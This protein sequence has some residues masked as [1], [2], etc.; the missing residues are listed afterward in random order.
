MTDITFSTEKMTYPS[1]YRK[2]VA[3]RQSQVGM[4]FL[5]FKD[6]FLPNDS[7]LHTVNHFLTPDYSAD[8]NPD[9]NLPMLKNETWKIYFKHQTTP[10]GPESTPFPVNERYT[11]P[12]GKYLSGIS[13]F[14]SEYKY[15]HRVLAD[16][17]LE[18]QGSLLVYYDYSALHRLNIAG[19][20]REYRGFDVIL[21]TILDKITHINP[22]KHNYLFIP[23]SNIVYNRQMYIRAFSALS[24][25]NLR[26]PQDPSYFFLV[27]LL[28]MI[29]SET[30]T[31]PHVTP[32]S[33]DVVAWT[34]EG[35]GTPDH[36]FPALK[37][38]SLF[39]R[40][41]Q[42]TLDRTNLILECN[43]LCTIFNLGDLKQ[44]SKQP[45][46]F[47]KFLKH[48][49]TLKMSVGDI[50]T[51]TTLSDMTD[52]DH[53][54]ET[55]KHAALA[56]QTL[57]PGED[58]PKEAISSSPDESTPSS[59][60]STEE[61]LQTK[62]APP[63]TP[64]DVVATPI[65]PVVKPIVTPPVEY[66]ATTAN[67]EQHV[68]TALKP[69]LATAENPTKAE[70]KAQDLLARHMAVKIGGKSIGEHLSVTKEPDI[71]SNDL[72]FLHKHL[73]D[74][75]MAKSSI[76]NLDTAYVDKM[77]HRDLA[78]TLTSF[79][80]SGMFVTSIQ[81]ENK[82]TSLSS[83]T[84]YK[85]SL[86]D[87][88]GKSHSVVFRLPNVD[89]TGHMKINGITSRMVKQRVNLP[90][91][92]LDDRRVNLS[93]NY[94]KYL[95]ERTKYVAHQYLTYLEKYFEL[96]LAQNPDAIIFR[97]GKYD[98]K[99][100]VLPYEYSK[101]GTKYSHI[102]FAGYKFVFNYDD[103]LDDV[104]P[105][106]I[107]KIEELELTYGTYCGT[108]PKG[109]YLF[110]DMNEHIHIV[111]PGKIE[112]GSISYFVRLVYSEFNTITPPACPTEWTELKYLN[113][114][115]P[116]VYVLGYR[117]GITETFKQ[118]GLKYRFIP[119]GRRITLNPDEISIKF[120]DGTLI[121][122]RYPFEKSLI[123][124]GLAKYK[125]NKY[126]FT[127]LNTKDF[128]YKLLED[129]R[130]STNYLKGI[131]NF[132]TFFIDPITLD[133]LHAMHEPVTVEGLLI[134][135]TQMLTT[136][137]HFDASSVRN[138]RFRGYERLA[139]TLYNE[140]A[141]SLAQY[142][143]RR[144]QKKSFSIN[145]DA[146]FYRIMQDNTVIN[147]DVIN[148]MH[149]QKDTAQTTFTGSNGRTRQS[150]VVSDR[151]FSPDAVGVISE[152]TP[153]SSKVAMTEYTSADPR[154][155]SMRGLAVP[156]KP[157]EARSLSPANI[158]SPVAMLLP[159]LGQDD[160]KRTNYTSIQMSHHVPCD[161]GEVSRVRTGYELTVAHRASEVFAYAAKEDGVIS[162]VDDALKILTITYKP[163]KIETVGT[164]PSGLSLSV[165][166]KAHDSE[167]IIGY[168]VGATQE[169]KYPMGGYFVI[170]GTPY[171]FQV[172]DR[173]RFPTVKAIPDKSAT[174]I[175]P[176]LETKISS[177][178]E[179]AAIYIRG[180]VVGQ[181]HEPVS[182]IVTFGDHYTTASGSSLRQP[183][184]L[185]VHDGETVK[186]GDIVAYNE[187]FFIPYPDTKQVS[188][189]HGVMANVALL[190]TGGT[191][192]DGCIIAKE[193]GE[194]MKMDS[195][196]VRSI[197]IDKST[198][199]HNLVTVGDHVE[200]T[201]ALCSIESEDV[202]SFASSGDEATIEYLSAQ[203]RKTPRARY[204]G[205]VVEIQV[206][207]CA[208]PSELNPTIKSVVD[209]IE[210]LHKKRVNATKGARNAISAAMPGR[211]EVGVK[212]HGVL[213]DPDTVVIEV[214][215]SEPII[216]G[217]GDKLCL[218]N[219]NKTIISDT[220]AKP[221][222]TR[223]GV[224]IDIL[225]ASTSV[226]NRIVWSPYLVGIANRVLEKA[227]E[228]IIAM[229]FDD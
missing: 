52:E 203:N 33:S 217:Q 192:E 9:V 173:T 73:P 36:P 225:F 189:K 171:L 13:H 126:A 109:A 149:E 45:A 15:L 207:Y 128:Y 206:F 112:I 165:Y 162:H 141:T 200:T 119:T 147:T 205:S 66:R 99:D 37:S 69:K 43:G 224:R 208:D 222:Y 63:P 204:A 87:V 183:I 94:N 72:S 61:P 28:G 142:N 23:L 124:A 10:A 144:T 30:V 130:T 98:Q 4:M 114:N 193:F 102:D 197:I 32:Y 167:G 7:V 211:V 89:R 25:Q 78:K 145:P 67:L 31:L 163:E 214:T 16:V 53:D 148:P 93:S 168:S 5:N 190:E 125:T 14:Y 111:S 1:F 227:E 12:I 199:I 184:V 219:A 2:Y 21:R 47:N 212:Y 50:T 123:A 6:I 62:A 150:F 46:F 59:A 56:T 74:P 107:K 49:N 131:D 83:L 96:I 228:N 185:N 159:G 221:A 44:M 182:E 19:R 48:I 161:E 153:D 220:M 90:I 27:H 201:D 143:N 38:T 86:S 60:P 121:F 91:C 39:D 181:Y 117:F 138:L 113:L 229:W 218:M 177:G 42:G 155:D 186:K 180:R 34:K 175:D 17:A 35:L 140:V 24:Q 85:V 129:N 170:K 160:P 127:E 215:I 41:D 55:D 8:I 172:L 82:S 178:K 179:D 18:K 105:S 103:R 84:H 139:G 132:F 80:S 76:A 54:K 108:S 68:T 191:L 122:S 81:E 133:V 152:A 29:Y 166:K 210:K 158:L 3:Y 101:I 194:R 135:A 157:G 64:K 136:T 154:I 116:I 115:F 120:S 88:N 195:A 134:R 187:G 164:I 71:T 209:Q 106:D 202:A 213:F 104:K 51:A 40:L 176:D 65:K 11:Y 77:L 188:W 226:L 198:T 156:A 79:I 95:V 26:N 58:T 22:I 75:T 196:H 169:L 151:R 137:E 57:P 216:A 223:S 100:R 110:W 97:Y 70:A 20:M 146:V 92:K 174:K 118:I